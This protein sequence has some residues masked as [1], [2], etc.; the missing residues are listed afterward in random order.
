MIE[1]L[2]VC[3]IGAAAGCLGSLMISKRISLIAGP[4]GHL[5]FPGVAIALL[6]ELNPFI[7]ALL[8]ILLGSLFM[9]AMRNLTP[10]PLETI[11]GITFVAGVALGLIFLPMKGAEEA[12]VG[13]VSKIGLEDLAFAAPIAF[14][15][16]VFMAL[17]YKKLVLANLSEELAKSM[18]I[19][20]KV[21]E[22]AYLAIIALI[23]AAE[24]KIVGGL[25]TIAMI[26]L[27]AASAYN[28]ANSMKLYI[29][30][31]TILG[32][33]EAIIGMTLYRLLAIPAGPA[34]IVVSTT[35]FIFSI[36][37]G[38]FRSAH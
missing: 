22:L 15:A 20:T 32:V 27:P 18:K 28:L 9:W 4:I 23:V 29:S 24:V 38:S 10:L 26:I 19:D 2:T 36:A 13:D 35:I 12:I 5:A 33:L 6:Y 17:H 16:L 11:A 37:I 3:L 30:L 1:I 31:S 25:L 14:I 34:I 21:Y 7:G 8:A